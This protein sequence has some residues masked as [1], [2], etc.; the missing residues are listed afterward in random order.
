MVYFLYCPNSIIA[1]IAILHKSLTD[2]LAFPTTQDYTKITSK[3]TLFSKL[4]FVGTFKY[5]TNWLNTTVTYRP[6]SCIAAGTLIDTAGRDVSKHPDGIP[7]ENVKAGDYVYCYDN[8]CKPQIKRVNWS[9][10]TGHKEII[11]IHWIAGHGKKGYLDCTPDHHIRLS[12]GTYVRAKYLLGWDQRSPNQSKR[13]PKT[14]VLSLRRVYDRLFFTGIPGK[15]NKGIREHRFIYS[16]LIGELNEHEIIHHLDSNHL[17]HIPINLSKTNWVEHGKVHN[18]LIKPTV[19]LKN[20]IAV[21]KGW[22]EGNY[23]NSIRYGSDNSK[24]LGLTKEDCFIELNR[25]NGFISKTKYDF[26]TFKKY[27]KVHGIDKEQI[28]QIKKG[29]VK[30]NHTITEIEWLYK[31]TDVYDLQIEDCHNFIANGICVHNSDPNFQN[32]PKHGNLIPGIPWTLLRRVVVKK[33]LMWLIGEADYDQAEVKTSAMLSNDQQLIDDCNSKF[34][35]HSHWASVLFGIKGMTLKE[36]KVRHENERYLAKNTFTFANFY[37]AAP[38]SIAEEMRKFDFYKDYVYNNFYRPMARPINWDK[39]YLDFSIDHITK[40]QN[41]FYS[42]YRGVKAW[43]DWVVDFYYKNHYI[44]NGFGFRRRYPMKRNEIINT[45]IQ[46]TSFLLL[47]DSINQIEDYLEKENPESLMSRSIGQIHDALVS[48]VFNP[49]AGEYIEMVDHF[50]CDKP[51]LEFT[52][53][54]K[55]G[56][57][58]SFGHNWQE[59]HHISY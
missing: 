50:M 25:I 17:N 53:K 46:G 51:H 26:D 35:M 42:R 24:Y 9:G 22:K 20:R 2:T 49:E 31:A 27:L 52:K 14:S 37:G 43:Q 3:S 16:Q 54:V 48:N 38:P 29:I 40:C 15:S 56:T 6:S 57:D 30:N 41:E 34:D 4:V 5:C 21:K 19:R 44:E 8:N 36:L 18:H 59:M 1:S 13:R 28:K 33:A 11:R 23:K 10:K 32:Q 58:W 12:N 45:P 55:M 47:Q 39:F 7:I